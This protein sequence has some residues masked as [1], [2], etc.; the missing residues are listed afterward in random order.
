MKKIAWL[1][2][3]GMDSH[4]HVTEDGIDTLCG[5]HDGY[6]AKRT[7]FRVSTKSSGRSNFCRTCFQKI[8]KSIPWDERCLTEKPKH[9]KQGHTFGDLKL[10]LF[11]EKEHKRRKR[12]DFA[13]KIS[14]NK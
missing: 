2:S 14:K 9:H 12:E 7:L 1:D 5:Q 10:E 4:I 13:K 11:W 6:I 3:C 8:K